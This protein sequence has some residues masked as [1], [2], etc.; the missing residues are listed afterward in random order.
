MACL[1]ASCLSS[2]VSAE[3][4][5]VVSPKAGTPA[6]IRAQ[7]LGVPVEVVQRGEGYETSLRRALESSKID[8]ICLAGYM[9]LLPLEIVRSYKDR[10]LNIHPALLPKYGGKGMYG[11]HVH[12]AVLAAGEKESGCT[13]HIVTEQYDEGEIVLQKKCPVL[14]DDTPDTLADRVLDL[15]HVAY[16]EALRMVVE[17]L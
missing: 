5:L 17:R 6:T 16:P 9:W 11:I 7:S 3:P 13:V 2:D 14:A 8:V 15:E 12:E 10:I 4:A 1:I